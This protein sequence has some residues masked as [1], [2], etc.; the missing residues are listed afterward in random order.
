MPTAPP[1]STPLIDRRVP[2]VMAFVAG[3]TDAVCFLGLFGTFTAFVTGT[4]IVLEVEAVS[5]GTISPIKL[6]VLITYIVATTGWVLYIRRDG[7]QL[8][9]HRDA[10]AVEA[11]LLALFALAAALTPTPTSASDLHTIALAVLATLPMTLQFV[12]MTMILNKHPTSVAIT[13]NLVRILIDAV[14]L[15]IQRYSAT[16]SPEDAART[17]AEL[18]RYQLVLASFAAGVL[19]GAALFKPFGLTAIALPAALLA[20]TVTRTWAAEAT[21]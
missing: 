5:T 3:F 20:W 1:A 7:R 17:R 14:E 18:R 2:A 6:V 8:R 21:S 9:R 4:L 13:G 12:T 19:L 10:L 11:A 15:A 16:Q